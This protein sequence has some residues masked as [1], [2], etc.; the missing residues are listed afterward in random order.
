MS[1]G[2]SQEKTFAELKDMLMKMTIKDA[3]GET[4]LYNH[5]T[6][7]FSMLMLERTPNAYDTFE[8]LSIFMKYMRDPSIL[9]AGNIAG[10]ALA[11]AHNWG[12]RNCKALSERFVDFIAAN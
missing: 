2:L 5:L 7:M 1:Q 9:P 12:I 6:E 10:K 3:A 4:N 11:N 8:E